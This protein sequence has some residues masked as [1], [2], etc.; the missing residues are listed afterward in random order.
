MSKHIFLSFL[1]GFFCLMPLTGYCDEDAS[2]H[3]PV[4]KL[5][6]MYD[7]Y[8]LPFSVEFR[9]GRTVNDILPYIKDGNG[10]M[11]LIKA[12]ELQKLDGDWNALKDPWK[13]KSLLITT[14][15]AMN[16][17]IRI[18]SH[19][20][21]HHIGMTRS[22]FDNLSIS[23][24]IQLAELL[25]DKPPE[26]QSAFKQ[27][28]FLKSLLGP[29]DNGR[30]NVFIF[31]ASWC[32]SCKEYRV[33]LESYLKNYPQSDVVL[34]SVLIEDPKEEIFEKPLLKELFPNPKKY[35]HESIPRF[36]VLEFVQGKP[37]VLEDGE[38]I[39]ALYERYLKPHRGYL[40]SKS[41]L[42]KSNGAVTRGLSSYSH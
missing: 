13:G 4:N 11:R 38:A 35:S 25:K 14:P 42:F 34:H 8:Y 32:D 5:L 23:E 12:D 3:G 39:Q 36:A 10:D 31:S 28:T 1:V 20:V 37:H 15:V 18:S 27:L 19:L 2:T 16:Q 26:V 33:L 22:A 40:D 30:F 29:S 21:S 41:A 6:Y 9:E 24:R 17:T 7:L